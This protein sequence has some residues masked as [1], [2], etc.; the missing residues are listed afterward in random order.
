MSDVYNDLLEESSEQEQSMEHSRDEI[1]L[2]MIASAN[3]DE[4]SPELVAMS[5]AQTKVEELEE[6]TLNYVSVHFLNNFFTYEI[7]RFFHLLQLATRVAAA[8]LTISRL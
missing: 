2:D 8:F 3:S 7:T 5:K 1:A 6:K 4:F